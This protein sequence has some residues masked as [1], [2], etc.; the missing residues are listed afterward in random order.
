MGIEMR[1]Y[2][3]PGACSLADHIAL[4]EAGIAFDPMKVDLKAHMAEDGRDYRTVNPKGY[5]PALVFDDGEMLTENI[6]ILSW[7]ADRA[8]ELA[9]DG[10]MGRYRLLEM[11]A[12]LST[13]LHKAFKPFFNVAADAADK[14]E[15]AKVVERRLDFIAERLTSDYLFGRDVCVA[16]P[17]LFVMLTWADKNG[18]RMAS[19]LPAYL[20]RMRA[21][22]AVRRALQ[23]E[24]LL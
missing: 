18:L 1:L 16:D 14:T 21:R 24:G 5:V 8:P 6:A 17:Y 4:E 2:F 7:I 9:V 13:E 3:A 23:R 10:E 22:P 15:A 12:Y 19:P 11:L 20:E